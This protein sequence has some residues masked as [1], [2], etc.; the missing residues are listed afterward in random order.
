MS[1]KWKVIIFF[2]LHIVGTIGFSIPKYQSLF[3]QVIPIHLIIIS[4]VMCLDSSTLTKHFLL[5]LII[6]F[7]I[8]FGAEVVGI[9]THYIFGNYIYSNLLGPQYWNTPIMIGVLWFSTAFAANQVA[10]KLFPQY[11]WMSILGAALIMTGFDFM[12]EPFAVEY[13]LW[14]WKDGIIPDFNYHCWFGVG[15]VLSFIYHKILGNSTNEAAP[16]FLIT[17]ILFFIALRYISILI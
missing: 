7:V 9:Q 5:F 12:I 14:S 3:Q 2:V 15:L 17:Q 4:I 16:Y 6:S 10:I 13:G 8:G 11:Q 1:L